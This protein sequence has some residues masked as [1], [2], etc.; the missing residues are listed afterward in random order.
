VVTKR[1][2]VHE[3]FDIPA[4]SGLLVVGRLS[5]GDVSAGTVLRT[6]VGDEVTV[7]AVEFPTARTISEGETTLLVPRDAKPH[8]HIHAVLEA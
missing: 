8:L 3:T 1:F 6:E 7:L 5:G 4:R 2:V